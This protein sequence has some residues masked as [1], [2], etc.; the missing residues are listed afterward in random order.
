MS[1]VNWQPTLIGTSLRL[2]PLTE[3]DFEPLFAAASDPLIWEQ[4]PDRERYKHDKFRLYFDSG[5]ESRGALAIIDP[6]T[7]KIIGSSRFTGHDPETASIEVGYTFLS[8]QYWG[9][10]YNRELKQLMLDY[11]FRFVDDVFFYVGETNYR[12]QKAMIK[13]GAKE[14]KRVSTTQL[15]GDIRTS[16]VY[17]MKNTTSAAEKFLK[18]YHARHP[19]CTPQAMADGLTGRGKSSY[20]L[21]ASIVPTDSTKDITVL[22]LACGDGFLLEKLHRRN[23]SGLRLIG[24]DM[25]EHELAVA[26]R[27]IGDDSVTLHQAKAQSIPLPD[28]SVDYVLCHMAIMLMDSVES[29]I[30][31]VRRVLKPGGKF[32]AVVGA[33]SP[34]TVANDTF[35]HLL[36]EALKSE[37]L[38]WSLRLGDPR[39]RKDDGVRVLFSHSSGFA[40][41]IQIEEHVLVQDLSVSKA[42]EYFMLTYDPELLSPNGL[43]DFEIKLCEALEKIAEKKSNDERGLVACPTGLRQ[44][45]CE[46]LS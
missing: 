23:Q 40:E 3:D 44:I 17:Q 43:R 33:K 46:R 7:G 45:T 14:V 19:G 39:I 4:H 37:G 8:R 11:A 28:A 30:S 38:T 34:K 18:A 32:S 25:S 9:K 27:R 5:I 12:S 21:L 20:D 36:D 35:I 42:T 31:E 15:G 1:A 16:V 13:I 26:R 6:D 24:V 41:P 22:D 10:G 2:R 29:V